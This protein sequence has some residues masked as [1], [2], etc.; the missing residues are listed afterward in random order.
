MLEVRG[1]AVNQLDGRR[2]G[3]GITKS[4]ASAAARGMPDE[5]LIA[6]LRVVC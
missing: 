2:Y 6:R 3:S 4:H 1:E 5:R